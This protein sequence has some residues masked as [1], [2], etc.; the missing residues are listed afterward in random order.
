[1]ASLSK[2][3]AFYYKYQPEMHRLYILGD[4][5]SELDAETRAM[6][7]QVGQQCDTDASKF[8]ECCG[9][10]IEQKF[11]AIANCRPAKRLRKKWALEYGVWPTGNNQ[12]RN[13]I[14]RM[15]VGVE[16]RQDG[17]DALAWVWGDGKLDVEDKMCSE[18]GSTVRRSADFGL[19]DGT[20]VVAQVPLATA[21][22][23][24]I[25]VDFDQILASI[26]TGFACI[27]G[28]NFQNVYNYIRNL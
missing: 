16:L 27:D 21:D 2:C 22:G 25:E 20:V 11:G 7:Q 28:S 12:P 6:I 10:L 23:N 1:M 24:G 13:Q 8:L 17:T 9:K 4:E 19:D 26:E 14:W 5:G 15:R 18:F 3:L